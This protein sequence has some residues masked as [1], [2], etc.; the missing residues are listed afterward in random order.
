MEYNNVTAFRFTQQIIDSAYNDKLVRMEIWLHTRPF[1][2][3]THT[4]Q[5]NQGVNRA[6]EYNRVNDFSKETAAM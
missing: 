6:D 4:G 3:K 1:N 2:D 5:I